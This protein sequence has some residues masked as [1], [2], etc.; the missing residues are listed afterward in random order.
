METVSYKPSWPSRPTVDETKQ[1][2][3][4]VELQVFTLKSFNPP[5]KTKTIPEAWEDREDS[6]PPGLVSNGQNEA[7]V[8]AKKL[9]GEDL[10]FPLRYTIPYKDLNG[11][12]V[13]P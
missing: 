3:A 10:L 7:L 12:L 2:P 11:S 4:G 8:I 9:W 13:A 1:N 5:L 6:I